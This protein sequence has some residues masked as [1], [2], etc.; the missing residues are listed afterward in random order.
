MGALEKGTSRGHAGIGGDQ[1]RIGSGLRCQS[2]PADG[3]LAFDA[4][5]IHRIA[6]TLRR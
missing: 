1:P 5:V 6:D 4:D 2:R 3:D